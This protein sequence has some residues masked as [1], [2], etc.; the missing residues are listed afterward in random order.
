[1]IDFSQPAD[2]VAPQLLVCLVTHCG[3]TVRLTEEEA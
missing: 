3:V 1:M 2:L